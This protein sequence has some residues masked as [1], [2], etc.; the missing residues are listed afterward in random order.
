MVVRRSSPLHAEA[1][2]LAHRLSE[3]GNQLASIDQGLREVAFEYYGLGRAL[4]EEV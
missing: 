3:G 4:V 2:E 1:G